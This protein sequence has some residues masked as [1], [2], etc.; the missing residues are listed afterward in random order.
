MLGPG[1]RGGWQPQNPKT[2]KTL[3]GMFTQNGELQKFDVCTVVHI[4]RS[5]PMRRTPQ[6][7]TQQ[8]QNKNPNTKH[9]P[10]AK[11]AFRKLKRLFTA[12]EMVSRTRLTPQPQILSS[13]VARVGQKCSF[14][15]SLKTIRLS[16]LIPPTWTGLFV[17]QIFEDSSNRVLVGS[18]WGSTYCTKVRIVNAGVVHAN[19]KHM[20]ILL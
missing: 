5:M 15:Y 19:E 3:K 20:Y 4:V 17:E 11:T 9:A 14:S 10:G 13:R 8:K 6:H 2:P 1:S 18:G 16:H 12:R 7:T